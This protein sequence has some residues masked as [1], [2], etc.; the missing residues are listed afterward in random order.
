MIPVVFDPGAKSEFLD[1]VRYYEECINPLLT[2]T[3]EKSEKNQGQTTV[4]N[5]RAVFFI[6]SVSA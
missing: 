2:L 3:R 6:L 1:A 5:N 4:F